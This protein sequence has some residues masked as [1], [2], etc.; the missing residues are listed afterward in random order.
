MF[1]V[2]PSI[3]WLDAAATVLYAFGYDCRFDVKLVT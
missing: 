3:R 1:V 2:L